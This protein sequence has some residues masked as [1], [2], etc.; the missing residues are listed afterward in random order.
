VQQVAKEIGKEYLKNVNLFDVYQGDKLEEGKKAYAL[1]FVLQDENKT[2]TDSEID[3]LMNKLI[4]AYE[5][6]L[7]AGI[8][9]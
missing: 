1:S 7:G 3:T 5:N 2:M 8:R 4:H 9:K 6:K